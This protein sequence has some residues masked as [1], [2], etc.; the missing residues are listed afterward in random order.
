MKS[1][2]HAAVFALAGPLASV[3]LGQYDTNLV[4]NPSFEA[5][6]PDAAGTLRVE[7]VMGAHLLTD[8]T[9]SGLINADRYDGAFPPNTGRPV[10]AG[11]HYLFGDFT[12]RSSV[13]QSIDLLFATPEINTGMARFRLSAFLGSWKFDGVVPSTGPQDDIATLTVSWMSSDDAE[14]TRTQIVGP[15]YPGEVGAPLRGGN[16]QGFFATSG[17]VPV[18]A[19]RAVVSVDLVRDPRTDTAFNNANVDLVKLSLSP[20]PCASP[21]S[22]DFND[23]G[24]ISVQDVFDFLVAWFAGTPD[25][26]I[27]SVGGVTVQDV[28]DFLFAWFNGCV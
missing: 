3:A 21:Y 14:L 16:F 7:G 17:V 4:R 24:I 2:M 10:G 27:N 1:A 9:V 5:F 13:S 11:D 22:G 25:A 20:M 18:G 26:N 15:N 28:F 8:W 23:S 12:P 6:T 19:T